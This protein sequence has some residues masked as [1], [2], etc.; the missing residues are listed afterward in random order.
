MEC[1]WLKEN[2]VELIGISLWL[3]R[4]RTW[5]SIF[6]VVPVASFRIHQ[7]CS[8]ICHLASGKISYKMSWALSVS[9]R[10][11][12][13][14]GK[15]KNISKTIGH[16]S[17]GWSIGGRRL[18]KMYSGCGK[19]QTL[20]SWIIDS[21]LFSFHMVCTQHRPI[22]PNARS[23]TQADTAVTASTN[24]LRTSAA[25]QSSATNLGNTG[26]SDLRH[27]TFHSFAEGTR[28]QNLT[29]RKLSLHINI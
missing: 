5:Q 21:V 22:I 2:K 1:F 8:L 15:G 4:Y 20:C 6:F 28:I 12:P 24:F 9:Y 10:T 25:A 14:S 23:C 17:V 3:P 11:A 26:Y 16:S 29:S 18:K 27:L 13:W 7:L 19:F